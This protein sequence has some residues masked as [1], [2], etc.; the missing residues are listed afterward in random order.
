MGINELVIIMRRNNLLFVGVILFM[1]IGY[2]LVQGQMDESSDDSFV[3]VTTD[4]LGPWY[5]DESSIEER[6]DEVEGI[7]V[8]DAWVRHDIDQEG[9]VVARDELLW[10]IDPDQMRYKFSDAF[11]YDEAGYI[12]E[13]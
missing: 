3:Y 7:S 8:I 1:V 6:F 5:L 2:I 11:A 4:S 13:A 12:I 9:N 10:H